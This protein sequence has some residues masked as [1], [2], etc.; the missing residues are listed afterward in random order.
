MPQSSDNSLDEQIREHERL[1]FRLE[2]IFPA[3]DPSEARMSRG[4][5]LIVLTSG[6]G[7][8]KPK[9][10]QLAD[11]WV[12]G[13]AGM[14]YR[15]LIPDRLGGKVIASHIRLTEGGEVPDY[16]HYHKIAF[17]VIYCLKGR[18]RVVYEDQG[19]PFWLEAGD[20]VLQPPE[21]RHRVL[22]CTAGAEV[23]EIT[24]PAEH[25]TRVE[26]DMDLPNRAVDPDR[27]FGG[28]RFFRHRAGR[29]DGSHTTELRLVELAEDLSRADSNDERVDVVTTFSRTLCQT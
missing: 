24:S 21:I 9:N 10:G 19:E 8:D 27:L 5:D 16:V 20:L 23:I 14:E 22:E 6:P 15:D 4:L 28:C 26:H 3:D 11:D 7:S 13:R 25:E 29:R 1:G 2:M 18:I 12:R 17:Q